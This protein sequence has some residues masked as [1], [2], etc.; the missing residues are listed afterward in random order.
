MSRIKQLLDW[1]HM[2]SYQ[3][4]WREN[5]TAYKV[6]ISE[7]MLQQ[8]QVNVVIPYYN[9]WMQ[10]FPTIKHLSAST[11]D[12]LLLLWQGLGY[13]NRVK[14]IFET[15][16]IISHKHNGEIP[17]DYQSLIA[18]KGI[19]DYTASA[20]LAIG[21]NIKAIPVDGNIHR[22][23]SRLHE[24][25][26]TK[27][28]L[29]II[30]HHAIQYISNTNPRDSVQGLMDLGREVCKPKKPDCPLCPLNLKCLSHQNNTIHLYPIMKQRKPIP[31]YDVVVGFIK[32]KNKFLISKR[33]K[34]KFL[35]GLWE[36]PGGKIKRGESDK[37]SLER[38][39]K[40]ETNINIVIHSKI[41]MVNH[42]YSHFK[43]RISLYEC[44]YKS[45]SPQ[46]LASD[47]IRWITN[48]QKNQFAFPS[49]THKLFQL[50]T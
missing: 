13:Y 23:I 39:I 28:Q 43:V 32:K 45:G 46:P 33:L 11:L 12:Q 30:Q 22:V 25:S 19:G 8:S 18:L 10:K 37:Q 35:G 20:I 41:G 17:N 3:F 44:E 16:Q 21:F 24:L 31:H 1:Y 26:A 9:Q 40:E 29:K 27:Y 50:I 15:T 34:N 38:E 5:Y 14:N 48:K 2:Q 4:P 6:W 49:A 7:I 42:Q 47:E 36:L